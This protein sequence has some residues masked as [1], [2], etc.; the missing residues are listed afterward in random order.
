MHAKVLM[1]HRVLPKADMVSPSAYAERGTLISLGCFRDVL[2]QIQQAQLEVLS[3]EAL[4]ERRRSGCLQGMEIVLTFDDGY[5]DVYR[6]VLPVLE[7]F[8]YTAEL[9]PILNP[10][11][12]EE[13]LPLDWYYHL[14]DHSDLSPENRHAYILGKERQR[15]N[16]LTAL[17]QLAFCQQWQERLGICR[18]ELIQDRLYMC[19]EEMVA[20]VD[21]GRGL[22]G[23]TLSH[24]ILPVTDPS[25]AIQELVSCYDFA[26]D[27]QAGRPLFFAYPDGQYDPQSERLVKEQGFSAAL[28]AQWKFEE[29]FNPFRIPRYFVQEGFDL[30]LL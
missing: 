28:T 19:R 16:Q 29:P 17:D 27:L 20:W 7:E 5:V 4:L 15:F 24:C 6:F 26:R 10:C 14:L 30:E 18:E 23:H 21:S 2:E 8:G 12:Q 25:V 13:I 3:L 9:Y 22:G 1:F 11:L